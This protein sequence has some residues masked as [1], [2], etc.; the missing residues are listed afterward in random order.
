[1]RGERRLQRLR[2]VLQGPGLLPIPTCTLRNHLIRC[3]PMIHV[4][5]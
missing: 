5:F 4:G 1:V 3:I 2:R